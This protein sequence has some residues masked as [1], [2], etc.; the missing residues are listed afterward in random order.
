MGAVGGDDGTVLVDDTVPAGAAQGFQDAPGPVRADVRGDQA[1]AAGGGEPA[2]QPGLAAGARA[3][4]E[5]EPVLAGQ[6]DPGQGKRGELARLVLD[7]RLAAGDQGRR[8][9]TSQPEAVRRPAGSLA[10]PRE[11]GHV[12]RSG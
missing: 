1:G 8:I 11:A 3:Q 9:A 7:G 12:P 4:V 2:Q 6:A 10:V 5:P